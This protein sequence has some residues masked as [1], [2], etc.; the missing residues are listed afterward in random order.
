MYMRID[1]VCIV[2]IRLDTYACSVCVYVHIYI[3][4]YTHTLPL[5]LPPLPCVWKKCFKRN[6]LLKTVKKICLKEQT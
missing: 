5:P 1:G 3:Y 2:Y 4:I 6:E